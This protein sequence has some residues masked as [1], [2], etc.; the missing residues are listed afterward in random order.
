MVVR[1]LAG[2]A[3]ISVR[4]RSLKWKLSNDDSQVRLNDAFIKANIFKAKGAVFTVKGT[5]RF[6]SFMQNKSPINII[7]RKNATFQIN[8]DLNITAGSCI[9][10]DENG[11]LKMAG[12]YAII[13]STIAV[14]KRVE[15]G[16]ECMISEHSYITDSH[17]HYI[18]YNGTP[19]PLQSDTTIGN[20]VWVCLGSSILKGTTIGDGCIVA[21]RSVVCG[22]TYPENPLIAG[23]P[24]KVIRNNCKWKP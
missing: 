7:L 14:Q 23:I 22:G 21:A 8:G 11:F 19:S 9:S 2:R 5:L 16:K 20:H 24:A 3:I 18:E 1:S 10:L 15:I 4:E 13:N 17:N 12:E 6:E